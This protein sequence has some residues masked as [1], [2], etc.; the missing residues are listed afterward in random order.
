MTPQP[1]LLAADLEMK[2]ETPES[3]SGEHESWSEETSDCGHISAKQFFPLVENEGLQDMMLDVP[4]PQRGQLAKVLLSY[5]SVIANTPGRT[6]VVQHYNYCR[7]C[8]PGTAEAIPHSI[9]TKGSGKAGA[10]SDVKAQGNQT[11]HKSLGLSN[12]AG[13]KKG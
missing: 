12:C 4:K 10:R 7:K 11:I 8:D 1:V 5:P 13:D 6:T 9:F 3:S 2:E